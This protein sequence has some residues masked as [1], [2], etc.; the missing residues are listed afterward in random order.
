MIITAERGN[1]MYQ[2]KLTPEDQEYLRNYH[3]EKYERPAVAAD[4]AIFSV[5]GRKEEMNS[6]R[7]SENFRK[8]PKKEFKILLIRRASSP[9][10]NAWALPGGFCK[11]GEDVY[12]TAQREL[13]EETSIH[14]AYLFLSDI[15]GDVGRDPRGW[16]ISNTFY[17]LLNGEAC[18]LRAGSDAWEA[19]WFSVSLSEQ[20]IS[21]KD[22]QEQRT[23]ETEYRLLLENTDDEEPIR[24]TAVVRERRGS[25]YAHGGK[26]YVIME[27]SGLAFDHGKI[28]V[29]TILQLRKNVEMDGRILFELM[30]EKFTLTELQKAFE[31]VL[32]RTL[33]AA[34]FR[35]KIAGWIAETGEMAEGAGHRPAKLFR[36][37]DDQD[38]VK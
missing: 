14:H 36:R 34:N 38:G 20:C 35:R 33:F 22:S 28:I 13:A 2:Y 5:H 16:I 26:D 12:E 27:N 32:G 30:P 10:R 23:G 21:E 17:S 19:R 15:F 18:R 25:S 37:G 6:M 4:I 24:L 29:N 11:K 8:M 31:V 9:F 3:I 1:K 7:D